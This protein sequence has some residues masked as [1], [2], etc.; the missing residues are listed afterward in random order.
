MEYLRQ[1]IGSAKLSGIFEL[2]PTLR[3]KKVDV[4]ILPAEN[5]IGLQPKLKRQFDFVDNVPPLPDSFFDPLPEEELEEWE[6]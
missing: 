3:D 5:D 6:L 1:T 2:P 4:I